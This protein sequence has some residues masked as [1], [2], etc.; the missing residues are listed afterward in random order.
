MSAKETR[1]CCLG[2]KKYIS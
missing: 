1:K 2:L